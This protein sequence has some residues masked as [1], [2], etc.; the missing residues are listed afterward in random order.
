M[1]A[2]ANDKIESPNPMRKPGKTCG[3]QCEVVEIGSGGG[4]GG[5]RRRHVSAKVVKFQDK[6]ACTVSS[7]KQG[8][9]C[10]LKFQQNLESFEESSSSIEFKVVTVASQIDRTPIKEVLIVNLGDKQ[11]NLIHHCENGRRLSL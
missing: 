1:N 11:Y 7:I 6:S 5:V 2:N 3:I 10:T 4:V 9:S 8:Q